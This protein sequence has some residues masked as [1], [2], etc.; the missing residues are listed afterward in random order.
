MQYN[1][2]AVPAELVANSK[3]IRDAEDV[4]QLD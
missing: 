2:N 4:A 1:V 3:A